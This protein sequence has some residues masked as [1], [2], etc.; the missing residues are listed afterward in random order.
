MGIVKNLSWFFLIVTV[1]LI[2][3]CGGSASSI[4]EGRQQ[5]YIVSSVVSD[6]GQLS[7]SSTSMFAGESKQFVVSENNGY[8]LDN[9]S[10]CSGVLEGREY[11]VQGVGADCTITVSFSK[12]TYR[13]NSIVSSGGRIDKPS[14]EVAFG[15]H[16]NLTILPHT[17]HQLESVAGCNGNLVELNYSLGPVFEDCTVDVDFSS[18]FPEAAP[19]LTQVRIPLVFHILDREGS[20]DVSR[21]E[22]VSQIE[23]TNR[24]FRQYNLEEL[25]GLPSSHQPYVADIGIQFYLADLDPAGEAHQGIIRVDTETSVFDFDYKFAQQNFGGSAPWPNDQYINIWVGDFRTRSGAIGLAGRA[26]IPTFAPNE[27]IGISIEESLVGVID[28]QHPELAQ[29]KTLTHELGHFFGLIGHTHGVISDEN[30]HAHLTCD[31]SENTECKNS[32]LH[33]NFMNATTND[34]GMKM[35]SLSQQQVIRAWL[36]SGPLVMLYQ[37]NLSQD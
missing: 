36:E 12:K 7:P 27:Y 30:N 23:A 10:G 19:P 24:H 17:D 37:N 4:P 15:N 21:E 25:E 5:A 1:S 3:A 32:Q 14:S 11:T 35:F 13:V 2:S 8:I 29:G 33:N 18:L 26:H 6:G 34:E 9:I 28:P 20:T 16:L 31:G 22:I